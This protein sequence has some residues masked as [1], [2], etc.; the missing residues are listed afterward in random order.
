MNFQQE[1]C[2]LQRLYC[3]HR[4]Y[5]LLTFNSSMETVKHSYL[6]GLEIVEASKAKHLHK[7]KNIA[8]KM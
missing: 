7:N 3:T 1:K 5:L 8:L 2:E 4:N 6:L